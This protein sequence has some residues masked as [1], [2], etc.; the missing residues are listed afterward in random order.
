MRKFLKIA[1]I[2]L[3]VSI[4]LIIGVIFWKFRPQ[5]PVGS[6]ILPRIVLVEQENLK[7]EVTVQI[8]KGEMIDSLNLLTAMYP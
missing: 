7:N 8:L 3:G 4:V 6:E 2:V 1:I 5:V